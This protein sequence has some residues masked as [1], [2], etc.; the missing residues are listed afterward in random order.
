MGV[1][2][3]AIIDRLYRDYLTPPDEQPAQS[4]LGSAINETASY[5]LVT[6]NVLTQEE[7]DS[8]GAGTIIEV[9][10]ELMRVTSVA[11]PRVNMQRGVLGTDPADHAVGAP[12]IIRPKYPRQAVFDAVADTIE[13]LNADL[14]AIVTSDTFSTTESLVEVPAGV[15]QIIGLFYR[16]TEADTSLTRFVPG[17]CELLENVPADISD[18][19]KAIMLLGV[20]TGRTCYYIY[21]TTFARPEDESYDLTV[22]APNFAD[23]WI[24]LIVIGA[25]VNILAGS[26]IPARTQ[27]F[28]TEAV[29]TQ[30]YP[31]GSGESISK[32]LVRIYE[33]RLQK[34]LRGLY[35]KVPMRVEHTRVVLR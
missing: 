15:Q 26:D 19:G 9:G 11:W 33:Y 21:K 17:G 28:I 12:V 23:E 10:R 30:G 35:R 5:L 3:S 34:A 14:Y 24:P 22:D 16:S 29:E 8:V 7:E 6:D 4:S 20:P 18:T 1:R 32:A 27:E 25:L 2:L 31:V 13:E